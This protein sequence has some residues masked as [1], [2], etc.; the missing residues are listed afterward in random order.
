MCH[1]VVSNTHKYIFDSDF[2]N[3]DRIKKVSMLVN[4]G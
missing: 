3:K 1:I 4:A 2:E